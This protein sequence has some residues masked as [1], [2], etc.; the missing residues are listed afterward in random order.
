MDGWFDSP[1]E[2][3]KQAYN[4]AVGKWQSMLADLDAAVANF[5]SVQDLVADDPVLQDRW[6][7][8]NGHLQ[9]FQDTINSVKSAITTIV[10]WFNS[11]GQAVS[12]AVGLSGMGALP[13]IAWIGIVTAGV[14]AGTA[15]IYELRG[16]YTDTINAQ[17]AQQNIVNSQ[18]N[19]PLIPF[20]DMGSPGGGGLLSGVSD[21]AKWITI[22]VLGYLAY[23]AFKETRKGHA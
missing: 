6:N 13:V 23:E 22:G 10:G 1:I 18:Q 8:A 5:N 3:A 16:V 21:T 11:A 19:K 14:A 12:S 9:L 2:S 4:D 15:L 17:I 20:L 7:T